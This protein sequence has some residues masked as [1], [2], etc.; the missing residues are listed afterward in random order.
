VFEKIRDM[1]A[2]NLDIN[3]AD[4]T[5]EARL[6]EDLGVDSI[7]LFN[8]IGVYEDEMGVK[9]GEDHDIK[10]VADLVT[11]VEASVASAEA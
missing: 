5:T 7:D 10:T 1:L 2:E 11:V 4:I 8:L 3:A 6:Y 9:I